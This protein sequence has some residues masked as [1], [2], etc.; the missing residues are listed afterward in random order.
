MQS[1]DLRIGNL[2]YNHKKEIIQVNGVNLK[3]YI[4]IN[5]E[6]NISDN[7]AMPIQLTNKWL[8]DLGFKT[9]YKGL[10]EKGGF[11]LDILGYNVAFYLPKYGEYYKNI[12]YV[13]ELQNLYFALTSEELEL[14]SESKP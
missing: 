4:L 12:N 14:K 9:K 2:I 1:K 10:Y 7:Y 8:L 13:H 6:Q 3:G 11:E 5:E